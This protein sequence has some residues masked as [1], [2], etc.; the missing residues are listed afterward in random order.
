MR[1]L[2]R[3]AVGGM[4]L[5][6]DMI[7]GRLGQPE[8]PEGTPAADPISDEQVFYDELPEEAT[9][10][11]YRAQ[12]QRDSDD[13]PLVLTG[14]LVDTS[15]RIGRATNAVEKASGRVGRAV[16]PFIS[17][18]INNRA[19]RPFWNG[20]DRLVA[21]GEAQVDEWRRLGQKETDQGQELIQTIAIS[22]VDDTIDYVAQQPE[23][24]ELVTSK[25]TSVASLIIEYLR[26]IFVSLDLLLVGT[27]RRIFRLS[28][29][30]IQ[31]VP[32]EKIRK[33][34]T[35]SILQSGEPEID[36]ENNHIG[37][38]AGI[39]GHIAA[40]VIDLLI[41]GIVL[42]I[43][44][45]FINVSTAMLGID[46][47]DFTILHIDLS[48]LL[49]ASIIAIVVPAL[50]N[51]LFWVLFGSTI[52]QMVIGLRVLTTKGDLPGVIRS[53]LR[54][55]IGRGLSITFFIITFFS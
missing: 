31:E 13:L 51:T 15:Y 33:G 55:T 12:P 40:L 28:P 38:Y 46:L 35:W 6:I 47:S 2:S 43:T 22:T 23:V 11:V 53:F 48:R 54:A 7:T 17:P 1:S 16:T 49:T 19:T 8:E 36:L 39:I 5:G 44:G 27:S 20:F 25:T 50:Y 9:I 42:T 4:V 52:G 45:W 10:Q 3:L 26:S 34:A 24:F 18:L 41:L 14:L 32:S 30:V 29:Y 21:R 37:Y